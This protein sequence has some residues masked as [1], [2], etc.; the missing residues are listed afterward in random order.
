MWQLVASIE[1]ARNIYDIT[2]GKLSISN[3]ESISAKE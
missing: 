3:L 2:K 1:I